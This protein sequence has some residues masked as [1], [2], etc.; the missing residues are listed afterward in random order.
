VVDLM[1]L[2][3]SVRHALTELTIKLGWEIIKTDCFA[4]VKNQEQTSLS[5][6]LQTVATA[7]RISCHDTLV[8]A[9]PVKNSFIT[10]PNRI[11]EVF[12]S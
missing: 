3:C 2:I 9:Y 6:Q 1:I 12:K 8:G 11:Y 4:A 5:G 10:I 7:Q